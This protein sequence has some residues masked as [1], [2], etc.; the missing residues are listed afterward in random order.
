[1]ILS[2]VAVLPFQ[3]SLVALTLVMAVPSVA[4]DTGKGD[5]S[6]REPA[7]KLLTQKQMRQKERA[8]RMAP[9]KKWLNEDVAYIITDEESRSF[10]TLQ[11]DEEREQFI[12]QFWL[13]RDP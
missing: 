2:K 13:R 10:R 6:G 8:I 7:A 1:M 9:W 5:G 12:S 4:Q 11:T 3:F